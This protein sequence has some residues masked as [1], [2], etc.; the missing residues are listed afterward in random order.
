MRREPVDRGN[1]GIS[2]PVLGRDR[3]MERGEDEGGSLLL[4]RLLFLEVLGGSEGGAEKI[5]AVAARIGRRRD[6]LLGLAAGKRRIEIRRKRCE[7]REERQ[8]DLRKAAMEAGLTQND[9]PRHV[10]DRSW[11]T[12]GEGWRKVKAGWNVTGA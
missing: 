8:K 5:D 10:N 4:I 2:R 1:P 3:A 9:L 12:F 11:A 7:Q 6:I